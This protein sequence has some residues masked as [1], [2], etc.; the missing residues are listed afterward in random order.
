MPNYE[1]ECLSCG[2]RFERFQKMV[3]EPI[4]TCPKCKKSVRRLIGTGSGIIFKGEGFYATDY[5]KTKNLPSTKTGKEQ[6]ACSLDKNP[7]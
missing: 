1:Y 3:D 6:K 7:K 4:K 5:R 2:Y